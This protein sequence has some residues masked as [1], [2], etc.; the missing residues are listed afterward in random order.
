MPMF[1]LSGLRLSLA[2]ESKTSGRRRRCALVGRLQAGEA[3]Q[4]RGLAAAAGAE[5]D[6]ELALLDLEARGRPWRWSAACRRSAW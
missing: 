5:Q 1:R 2:D 6:Q 3:A 4:R